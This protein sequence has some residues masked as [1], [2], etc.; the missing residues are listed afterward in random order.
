MRAVVCTALG[1]YREVLEV[2]EVPEPK[3]TP[4]GV[5]LRVGAAGVSFAN[6]LQIAG[7]HQHKMPPPFIPG[8]EVAGTVIEV[9]PDVT[10]V[11]VGDRV[12]GG[13]G[14]GCYA[15]QVIVGGDVAFKLPPQGDFA[16]AT[17]FATLY[18][19]AWGA[20]KWRADIQPAEVLLVSGAAGGTGLAAIDLGK[21]F[22]ATVVAVVGGPEKVV[23]ALEQGAD[24][25]IDHQRE[26]VR[27][28][29]LALTAGRGADVVFD[30]VGGGFTEIALR[31]IAPEGRLLIIGFAGGTIPQLPA[32]ILLLKNIAAMG[33]YWG[34]YLG[35]GRT[36]PPDFARVRAAYAEMMQ[37]WGAG[38][39]RPRVDA[40]LPL[41]RAADALDR[42]AQRRAIGKVVL[43]LNAE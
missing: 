19:T 34:T 25:A 3:L 35:W 17:S 14:S 24:H 38:R 30:P 2:R 26:D 36:P 39:L 40:R 42:L 13:G 9:A 23:A 28:R 31:C 37:A 15:E 32:N 41:A 6:I 8:T 16:A 33:I 27:E 11:K 5:R 4:G 43:D 1:P 21:L 29:V 22:G 7:Q 20:L 12:L 18:G 10:A